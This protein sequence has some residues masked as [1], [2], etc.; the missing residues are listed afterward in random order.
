ME[1]EVRPLIRGWKVRDLAHETRRFRIFDKGDAVLICGGIGETAARRAAEA[2]IL[3][4]QPMRI[5]SV[6][7]AGGLDPTMKVADVIEPR[8][9]ASARDGSRTHTGSGAGT[10]VSYAAVADR[11]QKKRLAISYGAIAVDMEA[12][13]VAMAAQAHGIEFGA[14][15]AISDDVDFALPPTEKFISSDGQFHSGSFGLHVLMRPWLWGRTITLARNSARASRALCHAVE[16]YLSGESCAA[17][18][19]EAAIPCSVGARDTHPS[20]AGGQPRSPVQK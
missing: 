9:V 20:G 11:D 17:G 13:A 12:A 19:K 18:L 2:V 16:R 15:K 3:A 5:L 10:L 7:F 1:R 6:G 14:L 4:T 8:T